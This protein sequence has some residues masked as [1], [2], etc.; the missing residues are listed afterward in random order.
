MEDGKG[1][2]ASATIACPHC[3]ALYRWKDALAN[4]VAKCKSCG[5][6]MRFP[7]SPSAQASRAESSTAQPVKPKVEP[8]DDAYDI[9]PEPPKLPAAV[10]PEPPE[11]VGISHPVYPGTPRSTPQPKR[12]GFGPAAGE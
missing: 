2:G 4:K 10:L 7:A 5:C 11:G 12:A 6:L 3:N 1:E 9:R 8:E